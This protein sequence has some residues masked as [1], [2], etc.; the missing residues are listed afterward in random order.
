MVSTMSWSLPRIA[1][2]MTLLFYGSGAGE[3]QIRC[4]EVERQA[5]L[6]IKQ[7]LHEIKEGFLSSWGNEEEKRDC[8]EWYGV[9]CSNNSDHVIALDLSPSSHV[10][11]Y[12][13]LFT[14]DNDFRFLQ[15]MLGIK[16]AL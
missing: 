10:E 1:F 8:C 14:E 6:K 9:Q 3:Q 4:I 2:F 16:S 11:R 15:E 12:A 5:L 7:D 13:V